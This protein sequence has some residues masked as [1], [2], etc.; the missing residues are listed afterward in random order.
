MLIKVQPNLIYVPYIYSYFYGSPKKE[1]MFSKL[2]F[3][4][5]YVF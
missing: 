1:L 3:T 2:D 4:E 5:Q